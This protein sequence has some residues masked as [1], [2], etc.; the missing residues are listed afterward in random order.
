MA[1]NNARQT[2][3]NC[4][5]STSD[6]N[7]VSNISQLFPSSSTTTA[8][9]AGSTGSGSRSQESVTIS[10]DVEQLLSELEEVTN[11]PAT[12]QIKRKISE[13]LRYI[14]PDVISA[15]IC[16]TGLAPRPSVRYLVAIMNRL[17]REGVRTIED[18]DRRLFEFEQ[19]KEELRRTKDSNARDL[20]F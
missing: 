7:K 4:N 1:S 3:V 10:D 6:C 14:S 8:A 19:R 18:W 17:E 9:A 15:A 11:Y 16:D 20:W 2:E 13:W 5:T 12:P